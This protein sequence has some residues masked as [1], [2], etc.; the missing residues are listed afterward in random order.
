LSRVGSAL[1]AEAAGTLRTAWWS[2]RALPPTRRGLRAPAAVA[3][4]LPP[5]P[6]VPAASE[7]A[8]HAVLRLTRQPC[9][10]IA[11]MRQAWMHAQGEERDVVIGVRRERGSFEAHA[12]VDGDAPGSF[13]GYREIARR[14]YGEPVGSAATAQYRSLLG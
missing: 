12:W 14:A 9:L 6:A 13:T 2:V 8:L 3:L 4:R 11:S 7:A 10:V 1:R 5:A